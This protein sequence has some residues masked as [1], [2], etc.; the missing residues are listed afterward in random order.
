MRSPNS[1]RRRPGRRQQ[2]QGVFSPIALRDTVGRRQVMAY[3]VRTSRRKTS[4]SDVLFH[5]AL[6]G[7][8]PMVLTPEEFACSRL[9]SRGRGTRRGRAGRVAGPRAEAT[10]AFSNADGGVVIAGVAPDGR[11]VWLS[12]PGEKAND[13]H[14]GLREARDPDRHDVRELLVDE[15]MSLVLS[16]D[17]RRERFSQTSSGAVLVRRGAGNVPLPGADLSRFPARRSFESFEPTN[18]VTVRAESTA[19]AVGGHPCI[20]TRRYP[21]DD[22]DPGKIWEVRGSV[23][24]RVEQTTAD[25][26]GELRSIIAIVAVQRVEM[27]KPPPTVIREAI[28]NAIAHC[29]SEHA[30]RYG[31]PDRDPPDP[32]DDH[33]SG[34][35]AR[36]GEGREQPLP[37]GSPK[38]S[39]ARST[40]PAGCVA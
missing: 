27:P 16:A 23:D 21:G 12:R 37:A 28:A 39:P 32:D 1:H 19:A 24:H 20:G 8:I 30:G 11:I 2:S 38:R 17:R 25:L 34:K 40:S 4:L 13:L 6:L 14:Q 7:H 15:K 22:P 36:T 18:T 29:S 5:P 31:D 3:V 9:R 10:G 26:L 35:A 33:L